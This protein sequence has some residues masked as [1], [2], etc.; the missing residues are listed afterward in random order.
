MRGPPVHAATVRGSEREFRF[1]DADFERIR[2]LIRA[3]SGIA[4]GPAKRN[5]VYSRVSRL[6]RAAGLTSFHDYLEQ[7]ETSA[8]AEAHQAFVNA[9][10]TNLTSFFRER[11]HFPVLARHLQKWPRGRVITI[12]CTASSTGEEAYSIAMTACEAFD[13]LAPPV[14]IVASDIDTHVLGIAGRG[15]YPVERVEGVERERLRRFFQRGTGAQAGHVRVRPE[16]RALVELRQI[17]L[18][19]PA[20]P[21]PTDLAAIFCRNVLIYFDRPTQTAIVSRFAPMLAPAG[22][23]FAGHSENLAY[24]QQFRPCGHT[25]HA[26]A[27]KDET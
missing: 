11:H 23:L 10:T 5:L 6:V 20:W 14:R 3:R 7:L 8:D 16:L 12:W 4:M 13:S 9:L 25:V 26:L 17:N 27:R 1:T 22:L 18:L 24:A 19:E 15:V 2:R 21:V